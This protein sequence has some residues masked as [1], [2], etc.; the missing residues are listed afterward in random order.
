MWGWGVGDDGELICKVRSPDSYIGHNRQWKLWVKAAF[1]HQLILHMLAEK[2]ATYWGSH[3]G[4]GQARIAPFLPP[5]VFTH[6]MW[7]KLWSM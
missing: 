6:Q 2:S 3:R 5:H 7:S 1:K 4:R